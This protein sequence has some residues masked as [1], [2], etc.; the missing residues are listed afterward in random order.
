MLD[1]RWRKIPRLWFPFWMGRSGPRLHSSERVLMNELWG[2]E[3]VT[4]TIG[5]RT[6]M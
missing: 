6:E 2:R 1:L 4:K 5:K 3:I